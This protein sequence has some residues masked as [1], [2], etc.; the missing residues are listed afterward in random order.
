MR[1]I[2]LGS[3]PLFFREVRAP[4][5]SE[6][7]TDDYEETEESRDDATMGLFGELGLVFARRV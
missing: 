2:T 4:M 3:L 5:I 1:A 7:T 6:R